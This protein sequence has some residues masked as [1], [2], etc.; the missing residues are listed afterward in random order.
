M[1]VM[2]SILYVGDAKMKKNN[3]NTIQFTYSLVWQQRAGSHRNC[4]MKPSIVFVYHY[5]IK[6]K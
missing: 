5:K 6:S 2:C 3:Y 4:G 1:Y